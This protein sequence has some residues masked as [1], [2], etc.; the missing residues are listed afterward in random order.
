M[1][2]ASGSAGPVA[3]TVNCVNI[4]SDDAVYAALTVKQTPSPTPPT[5]VNGTV[6]DRT[7]NRRV[8]PVSE[9][10]EQIREWMSTSR[11][12]GTVPVAWPEPATY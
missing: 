3:E 1:P 2:L 9:D 5:P 8:V 12:V 10:H 11:Y 4:V 6:C 7:A